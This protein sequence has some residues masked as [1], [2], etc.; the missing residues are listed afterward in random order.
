MRE[1]LSHSLVS[2][3]AQHAVVVVAVDCC[4]LDL[5]ENHFRCHFYHSRLNCYHSVFVLDDSG[6]GSAVAPAAAVVCCSYHYNVVAVVDD[7]VAGSIV[8]SG[9]HQMLGGCVGAPAE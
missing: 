3:V 7:V 4:S 1:L 2:A 8:E 6:R 9:Q 5:L